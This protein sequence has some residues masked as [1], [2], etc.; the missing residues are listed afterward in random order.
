MHQKELMKKIIDLMENDSANGRTMNDLAE[1]LGDQSSASFKAIVKAVA[2]LERTGKVV[3][4]SEGKFCLSKELDQIEGTF[5]ATERGFGFVI[6]PDFE[7]DI[8]IPSPLTRGALDGDHVQVKVTKRANPK[9][10]HAAEGKITA[11]TK[12][13][14]DQFV[15]LYTAYDDRTR[16][17]T[18][19]TGY[20]NIQDSKMKNQLIQIEGKGLRPAS[21]HIVLVGITHFPEASGAD[22]SGLVQKII[23]HKDDP[24]VEILSVAYKHGIRHE[25]PE[26]VM[27]EVERIPSEVLAHEYDGRHD[28]RH[29]QVITIDGESAKDL[30]DAIHLKRL[31]NGHFLLGVHIADVAHYVEEDSAIDQEAFERGTSSYLIDRVIPMLP[32]QLSN[33]I[34]S[35]NPGVDRLTLT[36]EMEIDRQ[37]QVVNYHIAPSVINSQRRMDY[38]TV[39]A[40]LEEGRQDLR[41]K[42]QD[43]VPMLEGMA[44]LHQILEQKRQNQGAI[45]FDSTEVD[46]E[47]DEA[48]K[49]VAIHPVERGVG[50]RLIESFMLVANETIAAHY[51]QMDVPF[52]YRVHEHPDE[53]KI[54]NFVL[55]ASRF[56]IQVRTKKGRISPK[57]LQGILDQVKGETIEPVISMLL[58][59]SM[60]QA[61]YDTEPLGHYGL[62]TE[63]YSHFTAPI[64]RYPDLI[65]HRMI[66]QYGVRPKSKKLKKKW[67][68]QLPE[69][70]KQTSMA[71]RRA[72]DAERE[73][74]GIKKAEYM[75]QFIGEKFR[76]IITSLTNFGFFVQLPN[77]IEGLVHISSLKDDYYEYMEEHH[78]L[79]GS[80]TG[81]LYQIGQEVEV[82]LI[83]VNVSEGNIDF[84]IIENPSESAHEATQAKKRPKKRKKKDKNKKH[85][86]SKN[87]KKSF[88]IRKY[89]KNRRD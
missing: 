82:E 80:R 7:Q 48:G 77:T 29:E 27:A 50:E 20:V 72:V 64:R 16:K 35:L 9:E 13:K 47:V 74:E 6:V 28:Y 75:A 58:L 69:I 44:E 12:R 19:Y 61:R 41:Q 37:G 22:M 34:C 68:K 57:A 66:H 73:I 38:A 54:Q 3:I 85:R 24:G 45:A 32:Q 84:E 49:P 88:K 17:E 62:A 53:K 78:S 51:A 87:K 15:G 76:G 4:T 83:S 36:C 55:F 14:R 86:N 46:I 79:V 81:K 11:I 65:L 5:S 56:G 42:Y 2:E 89:T 1:A 43:I 31:S 18:G 21:G 23:G 63:Y 25:F 39:N 67:E 30:D 60:Q 26:E 33:G 59:R 8:F 71:E 10:G 52:L 40:I 70:A